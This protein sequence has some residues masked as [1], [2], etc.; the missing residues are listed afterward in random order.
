MYLVDFTYPVHLSSQ[1]FEI[2]SVTPIYFCI[3]K[4]L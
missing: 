3:L 4:L 2:L 1:L